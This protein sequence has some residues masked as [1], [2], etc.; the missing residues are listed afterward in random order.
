MTTS[1]SSKL[2]PR[3]RKTRGMML[4]E[5]DDVLPED[6]SEQS[7]NLVRTPIQEQSDDFLNGIKL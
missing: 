7:P 6:Q 1:P 3:K 2:S 4:A 5:D